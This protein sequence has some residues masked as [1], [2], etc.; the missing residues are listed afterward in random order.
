MDTPW[1][2]YKL[3]LKATTLKMVWYPEARLFAV[4][5]SRSAPYRWATGLCVCVGG[6]LCISPSELGR[7]G[8]ACG[9]G[10]QDK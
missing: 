8:F 3:P 10:L 2:C 4:L 7:E 6:D 1:L 9:E 5:T